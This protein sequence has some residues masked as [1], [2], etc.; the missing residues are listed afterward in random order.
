MLKAILD[1][2]KNPDRVREEANASSSANELNRSKELFDQYRKAALDR[3]AA[4]GG[5]HRRG[6]QPRRGSCRQRQDLGDHGQG[7]LAAGTEATVARL[8]CCCWPLPGMPGRR[9]RSGFAV[10]SERTWQV[11]LP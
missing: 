1:F 2:L 5:G 3:G 6:P 4:Q 7:W 9:W 10:G 8:N 11:P